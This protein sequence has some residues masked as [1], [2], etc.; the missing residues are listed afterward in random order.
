MP[1][2]FTIDMTS[3]GNVSKALLLN[4][5]AGAFFQQNHVLLKVE[6]TVISSEDRHQDRHQGLHLRHQDLHP[7]DR[8]LLPDLPGGLHLD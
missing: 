8:G 1:I 5:N 4:V 2:L 3:V 6:I 7:R